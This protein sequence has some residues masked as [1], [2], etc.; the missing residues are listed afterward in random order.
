M[1]KLLRE[2]E[3][4]KDK[5]ALTLGLGLKAFYCFL[6]KR[7]LLRLLC[8]VAYVCLSRPYC[9]FRVRWR[10]KMS[11]LLLLHVHLD[12]PVARRAWLVPSKS[13]WF[14][15]WEWVFGPG[16]KTGSGS[17]VQVWK[18]GVWV[19]TVQQ[20]EALS[21]GLRVLSPEFYLI[22]KNLSISE[23]SPLWKVFSSHCSVH[24]R[25]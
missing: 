19:L 10:P 21:T 9:R 23:N 7:V 24:Y 20:M 18:L 3:S 15:N 8:P 4:S 16:L 22:Y 25:I 1:L 12:Q 2:K 11:V 13:I 5:A 6:G 14:E 17:W